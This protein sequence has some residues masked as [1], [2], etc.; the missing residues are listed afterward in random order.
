MIDFEVPGA[1]PLLL[2]S[3]MNWRTLHRRRK[4]WK[5]WVSLALRACRIPDE[6]LRSAVVVYDRYCGYQ[7]PDYDNLVSS[8]KWVQD[9]I[10]EAGVVADDARRFLETH[11]HWHPAT[12]LEKRIR[13][14]IVPKIQT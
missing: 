7:E 11:H 9:A 8:F 12:P 3:R 1:P 6:P 14:R 4:E 2:N 10:V 5:E 13:V